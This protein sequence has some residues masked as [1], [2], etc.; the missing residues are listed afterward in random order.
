MKK[1]AAIIMILAFAVLALAGCQQIE[2]EVGFVSD[3][4]VVHTIKTNGSESI[5]LPQDPTKEGYVFDGWYWDNGTW[6]RP[7]TASSLLNEPLKSNMS[8]YAKWS[9]VQDTTQSYTVTFNTMGGNACDSQ[10]I[11]YNGLVVKPADPSKEGYIFAGW[12]KEA[13]YQTKWDFTTDK[14]TSEVTIYAKWVSAIDF[15]ACEILSIEGAEI[16]GKEITMQIPN[17]QSVVAI[18][19]IIT[20]SPYATYVVSNDISGNDQIA[21]GTVTPN[22]GENIYYILVT[23]NDGS[24]KAQYTMKITREPNPNNIVVTVLVDGS[25]TTYNIARGD[26]MD[27]PKTPSKDGYNF[28]CWLV[29]GEPVSFP[30]T[31]SG[32]VTLSAKWELA[33]D[34]NACEVLSFEGATI[35]GRE[36]TMQIPFEQAAVAIPNIIKVSPNATYIVSN[37]IYSND[38]IISGTVTPNEGENIYYIL[39]ISGDSKNRAQY[40]LKITRELNP[41]ITVTVSV[42]G[43]KTTK[44]VARGQAMNEPEAPSKKGYY[45]MNWLINGEPVSFPYTPSENVTISANWVSED[46]AYLVEFSV[47]SEESFNGG[48]KSVVVPKGEALYD[49]LESLPTASKKDYKFKGWQDENGEKITVDTAIKSNIVLYPIWEKIE[50]CVDG[51]ENHQWSDWEHKEPTCTESGTKRRTCLTCAHVEY[52]DGGEPTGHTPSGAYSFAIKDGVPVKIFACKDCNENVYVAFKPIT[53]ESFEAPVIDGDVWWGTQ[54]VPNLINGNFEEENTGSIGTSQHPITITLEAKES[55]YVDIIVVSGQGTGAHNVIVTYEDGT[56]VLLG[57]GNIGTVKYYEVYAKISKIT[58]NMES[59]NYDYIYEI[60]ACTEIDHAENN[61][62]F[63]ET[64]TVENS[65]GAI[66]LTKKCVVCDVEETHTLTN[67]TYNSFKTPVV[68]GSVYGAG[69]AL[70]LIDGVF[71]TSLTGNGVSPKGEGEVS[72]TLDAKKNVYIDYFLVYGKGVCAYTV[73]VTYE[74]G[75]TQEIGSSSFGNFTI[76]A[77][78]IGANV[79]SIELLLLTPGQCYDYVLE[80]AAC[81]IN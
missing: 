22:V 44:E 37:D 80:L 63:K 71:P 32:D 7:F 25:A 49:I 24:S 55:V 4:S 43:S 56:E 64:T 34:L 72:F 40:T 51:T 19:N 50:Y 1:I 33:I 52:D 35:N 76:S 9:P 29:D 21:S 31:P 59:P 30:Y 46:E 17:S 70:S 79:K 2:F 45:F 16:N 18:A 62:Y 78:E 27:A 54:N 77:F 13:D 20:V 12:Y 73:S 68:E 65:T 36:I 28:V 15:S 60:A 3:G 75:S 39:V 67:I 8:V 5:K 74:D 47:N 11:L 81:T 42:D 10:S 48:R 66:S 14:I 26:A 69:N 57:I 58:F 6:Q 23:S 53:Y 38:E 41:V 61:H